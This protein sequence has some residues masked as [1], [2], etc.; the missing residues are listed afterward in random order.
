MLTKICIAFDVE[1]VEGGAWQLGARAPPEHNKS[2]CI[3]TSP[4]LLHD[5]VGRLD[6]Q[7]RLNFSALCRFMKAI[8]S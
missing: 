2:H 4:R 7:L 8:A 5:E 1:A 6:V 3:Y